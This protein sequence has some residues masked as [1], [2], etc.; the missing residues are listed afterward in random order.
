MLRVGKNP[1]FRFS[2]RFLSAEM[3]PLPKAAHM[4]EHRGQLSAKTAGVAHTFELGKS[5]IAI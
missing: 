4:K 1:F 3:A 5:S 2:S